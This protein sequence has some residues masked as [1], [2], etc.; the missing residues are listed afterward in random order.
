M[1]CSR[2]LTVWVRDGIF[3]IENTGERRFWQES[4]A[5]HGKA[6]Y[7]EI[8]ALPPPDPDGG[9]LQYIHWA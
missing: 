5:A 9:E 3:E 6:P 2:I 1:D 8:Y 4:K 7:R